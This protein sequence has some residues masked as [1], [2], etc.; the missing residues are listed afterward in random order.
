MDFDTLKSQYIAGIY[1]TKALLIKEQ[2]FTLQSGKKSHVYLNHRD[3]LSTHA[4]LT[5][6]QITSLNPNTNTFI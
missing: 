6:V 5:L 2:P 1:Q 4:Y 3:F